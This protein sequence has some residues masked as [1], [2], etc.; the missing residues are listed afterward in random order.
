MRTLIFSGMSVVALLLVGLQHQRIGNLR[1]E[2]TTLQQSSAEAVQFKAEL[3]KSTGDETQDAT[4][5]GRLREE[6]R[7]LLRLRNEVFQLRESKVQFEKVSAENQRLLAQAK[8]ASKT[9]SN[10]SMQPVVL[11]LDSVYNRGLNTPEDALQTYY[12]G[13]REGNAETLSRCVT[14]QLL[15]QNRDYFGSRK[16][17]VDGIVSITI[18]ARR[19]QDSTTVQL[20]IQV[21]RDG[22]A[23]WD[24]KI[25][26]V[27]VLQGGEW[28]VASGL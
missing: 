8:S 11:R 1:A 9:E 4:E 18:M 25:V 28:R 21:H 17:Q 7:D 6:N 3:A 20:G 24:R 2:N 12:W 19:D 13:L 27:L 14:P 26:F 16:P 5:M 22:D 23:Q 15:S 10:Q